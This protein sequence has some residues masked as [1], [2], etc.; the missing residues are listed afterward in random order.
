MVKKIKIIIAGGAG[1]V[2]S[3]L[4]LYLNKKINNSQVYIVDNLI[5]KGSEL[6]LS[7]I[8]NNNIEFIRADL[9][10]PQSFK[11]L[12]KADIFIDA[13]SNPSILAGINSSTVD[14]INNNLI[15][16]LHSLEWCA[17]NQSKLIF[18]SSNRIYP[19]DKL[20]NINFIE[21]DTRFSWLESL[22][23]KG[24]SKNGISEELPI[25]GIR[26][27]YG[28]SKLASENFIKEYGYF[29]N[30]NFVINRFG[31]IG[32]PWQMGKF[33]QGILA[34]WIA[35]YIY[36]FPL[37]YIGYGGSGKQVR[38]I[39]HVNDVC[40]LIFLQ[41]MNWE[42]I[43]FNTYNIGGGYNNSISLFELNSFIQ[44]EIGIKKNIGKD[45]NK[46]DADI[47][48]YYTDNSKIK[49]VIDWHPKFSLRE[50]IHDTSKW[51][52]DNKELLSK[53]FLT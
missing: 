29:K 50:T 44:E 2:G 40:N 42:K 43:N 13:A 31:I 24:L 12:P 37:K 15:T 26:S 30:L 32:G 47:P 8:E 6:N 35:A 46:R 36:N 5:R 39:L 34:Y 33:D 20:N 23:I 22:K 1:F 19:F 45:L 25:E 4:A 41:I 9:S 21:K 3:S 16:T 53:I 48:I 14:L 49:E 11:S 18:L 17:E 52:Y 7:R 51:V 28:A 10:N 27:F 38:D